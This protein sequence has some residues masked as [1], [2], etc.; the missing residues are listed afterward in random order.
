MDLPNDLRLALERALREARPAALA[1]A[2]AALSARYREGHGRGAVELPY[3]HDAAGAAAYAAARMPATY[4][5]IVAAARATA[6]ALPELAPRSLLDVGG[7]TGSALWAA[8]GAWESL[9]AA[10]VI[11]R[12]PAMLALGHRLAAAGRH[13]ALPRAAWQAADV[14]TPWQAEQHDLVSAAYVLGELDEG[15]R[16]ALVERLWSLAGQAL[17]IVEPGTPRGFAIVRAARARLIT[18]GA[19]IVAP[20]PHQAECP[21]AGGDWCHF[22]QRVARTREQRKAKGAELGYEDEKYSYVAAARAPGLP[23]AGR[24]LRHPLARPGRVELALCAPDGLRAETISRSDRRWRQARD[25]RWGDALA[26]EDE[27]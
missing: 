24:I 15:P 5:A 25:L 8:V 23:I 12:E 16:A 13:P 9:A 4:A 21:M 1:T 14:T 27:A 17:L 22:A 19:Q 3:V 20:C 11:E 26:P 10:T 7:G 6:A 18:L 2:A